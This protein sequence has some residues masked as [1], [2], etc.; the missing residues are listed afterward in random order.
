MVLTYVRML[1]LELAQ[2]LSD[3]AKNVAHDDNTDYKRLALHLFGFAHH[4]LSAVPPLAPGKAANLLASRPNSAEPP[5]PVTRVLQCIETVFSKRRHVLNVSVL[6]QEIALVV[7]ALA[8]GTPAGGGAASSD[9]LVPASP[10]LFYE[11]TV[12]FLAVWLARFA[13]NIDAATTV[14]EFLMAVVLTLAAPLNGFRYKK[15]VRDML[16]LRVASATD[17]LLGRLRA[18]RPAP[19]LA[20]DTAQLAAAVHLFAVINDHEVA[21]KLLLRLAEHQLQLEALARKL[22]FSL[23]ACEPQGSPDVLDTARSVLL[24]NMAANLAADAAVRWLL[25]ELVLTWIR[26]HWLLLRTADMAA[27]GRRYTRTGCLVLLRV[28]LLCLQRQL[29]GSFAHSF[30]AAVYTTLPEW[31]RLPLVVRTTARIVGSAYS[32]PGAAP[33]PSFGDPELDD[34]R[35]QIDNHLGNK[36][37]TLPELLVFVCG[38]EDSYETYLLQR[39]AK[40]TVKLWLEYIQ[41]SKHQLWASLDTFY[42]FLTLLRKVP[43]LLAGHWDPVSQQCTRCTTLLNKNIYADVAPLPM[44]ANSQLLLAIYIDIVRSGKTHNNP[45][46]ATNFLL[47]LFPLLASFKVPIRD[48]NHPLVDYVVRCLTNTNRDVRLLAARVLPL[49][50][51]RED[52][53]ATDALFKHFFL[54]LSSLPLSLQI[55]LGESTF[56]ALAELAI[57]SEGEWL[58]VLSIKL[59]DGLGETNEQHLNIAYNCLL[60][61]ALARAV[62]PYK[63]LSPFLPSIAER[64][65]KKPRMFAKLVELIGVSRKYFLNNT[66]EYTTPRFLEYY[67]HDF[68]QEI[69]DASSMPKLK[70]IHKMLPRIVATYLCKD[71]RIDPT[72]IINVLSNASPNYK[73]MTLDDLIP[74]V[75]EVLW[76]VLLQMHMEDNGAIRNEARIQAA[77]LYLAKLNWHKRH[78][79]EPVEA[80]SERE[81]DY[82]NDVLREHVLELVQHFS[83]NVHL[84]K[85]IKPYLE[86]VNSIKA[87]QFI[88]TRNIEAASWALGQISTCLQAAMDSPAL[89][90]H[91]LQCWNVLVQKLDSTKLV[92]LFDITISLMFQ[93]FEGFSHRCKT[94]AAEIL[95]KLFKEITTK[96]TKYGPYYY[97]YPYIKDLDKYYLLDASASNMLR[98][99]SKIAF[100]PELSR[101]LQTSNKVVVHQALDDLINSARTYQQI[102]QSESFRDASS[103]QEISQLIRDILDVAVQFKSKD[104]E[105]STKCAKV[106]GS[107]GSLDQNRFKFQTVK[108]QIIVLFDFQDPKENARFLVNFIQSKVIKNFWAS[109]DPMRQLFS[110]YAM[111]SFLS[112]LGLDPT[113]LSG[114]SQ[115]SRT[116][117]W[118]QF[119]EVDKSTLTPLLSSQYFAAKPRYEPLAFP[120]FSLGMTHEEWVV[121][122]TTNLF[123]RPFALLS[124]QIKGSR[125]QIYLTCSMLIRDQEVSISRYLLK[126]VALS[127]IVSGESSVRQDIL[128]EFL[129]VLN[130]R[131]S[132]VSGSD[133]AENLKSCYQSVFEALDYFNEWLSAATQRASD[134][135]LSKSDSNLLKNGRVLVSSFLEEISTEVIALASSECDSYERTILSLEKSY[136]DFSGDSSKQ[137]NLDIAQTLK[138]VYS[139]IDDYD[140]LDG[141][142]KKFSEANISL[143]LETFQYNENW[144]IAQESFTA[145]STNNNTSHHQ[146][147]CNTKLLK[148]FADHAL[149]DQVLSNL[150]AKL[151][152]MTSDHIPKA[153]ALAGLRAALVC[154]EFDLILKWRQISQTVG[155]PEDVDATITFQVAQSILPF[156][157]IKSTQV[158]QTSV[159]ASSLGPTDQFEKNNNKLYAVIG[160]ALSLSLSSSFSR[161]T[162]LMRQ[163]HMMF[164]LA[165]ILSTL[166]FDSTTTDDDLLYILEE[167]LKNADC[168]FDSQWQIL[169][170]HNLC[171]KITRRNK[172]VSKV[173]IKA[174]RLARAEK[175]LD[176]AT[177]CIMKAMVLQDQ[178]ATV[179]YA[180]LIWDQGKKAEAIKIMAENLKFGTTK[181]QA[182]KQ[183]QYALWL[184][185][186]SHTSSA[187][188]IEEYN[189]A[190]KLDREWEKPFFDLGKY[191]SKIMESNNDRSGHHERHIIRLYL[192]ALKLGTTYIFEALPK[193]ITVWLDFAQDTKLSRDAKRRLEQIVEDINAQKDEVPMYVW[194]TSITQL[195]SRITHTHKPSAEVI[196]HVIYKLI[197]TYPKHSLWYVLSHVKSKDKTRSDR[198]S[199]VLARVQQDP[200]LA[201]HMVQATELFDILKRLA[202]HT[203]KKNNNKRWLLSEDFNIHDTKRPYD[204]LVIPVKSNLEIRIPATLRKNNNWHAFPRAASIT[205]DGFDEEVSIFSSLQM[206][207][208]ITIRGSDNKPYRLMVKRDDTRKDAKVFE[209]TNMMNKLLSR[210]V[211]A[212]KR[213]LV[214]E[215]YS[216]IPLAEDMGVIEFV[217]NVATMKAVTQAQ[218][219]KLGINLHERKIAARLKEAQDTLKAQ[220]GTQEAQ[221]NLIRQFQEIC[222]EIPPVL[223]SWFVEQFSDPAVWYMARKSFTRTAAVMSIVGYIIGLGDRH[224]ENVLFLKEN[225]SVL[226]IDFDC[227]FDKGATLPTPEI[228]PFRL[229]QNMVDVMGTTGIEGTFRITCEVAAALVRQNEAPLMNILETLIHDPLLDWKTNDKSQKHLP[230]V[231]RKIRGL[232]NEFDGLPVSVHGQVDVL[233]Q[234]ATSVQ[235][236]SRMY[237]GWTPHI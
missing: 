204:L 202:A 158:P 103:E 67:K 147:D 141:V 199:R 16:V 203:V 86:K 226:H 223:H 88:I 181:Q 234:Q 219:K 175:R 206:P 190:Y 94:I 50:L 173:L 184:D 84:M 83:E 3:V 26:D 205:F 90:L 218:H 66:R 220:A 187:D 149:H 178:E 136:R 58:C 91:A 99:K 214:I 228:V 95:L 113:V 157:E 73:R 65:I 161:N 230:T 85:G 197:G 98:L 163:L 167:R 56:L 159:R 121:D 195:L 164:D 21:Q 151:G 128:D 64:I 119:S 79:E 32:E 74:N 108:Q 1:D 153:W 132:T 14:K 177:K 37:A 77:I 222:A 46:L 174:S 236:L 35:R 45:L 225:G 120:H 123:R 78:H 215:N 211:D 81:F 80:P 12:H 208:Q 135:L 112:I 25:L 63:L 111:Q 5:V 131:M 140:A 179:E 212:R 122:I 57:I 137:I 116:A 42:T 169:T 102:W 130:T 69:A 150:E 92:S 61:I 176:I 127:H 210:S 146:K 142:L 29:A 125:A 24:L 168:Q 237:I 188:I 110:V 109:N 52:G 20:A 19:F 48:S 27:V 15:T 8:P 71:D 183:L 207:K 133:K 216:V 30:D 97:S 11:W 68:I 152:L 198:V 49:F 209:F 138:S 192:H 143:K 10:V 193:L 189:K 155:I 18:A 213:K 160:Q 33:V 134:T 22:A 40:A 224:C 217:L 171:N 170:S 101:R 118:N 124:S 232:M 93:K 105:I 53:Q 31:G 76:F 166:K 145:L 231:R 9:E 186:S 221:N 172:E 23:A 34:V 191:H 144:T 70:L 39:N 117:V 82:I 229:T 114:D 36:T 235:N 13:A 44:D 87:V 54:T 4:K 185:E 47:A 156:L 51:I 89:E 139:G 233:I 104:P 154:G 200:T 162:G 60:Y 55:H 180:H 96:Y 17:R 38:A 194:Y 107:L 28:Y 7:S 115:A 148:S 100:F 59:V 182:R 126:Y 165:L 227:L 43:C 72:Y 129:A 62:T 41:A 6:P 201:T 75:G 106:L 196:M 2:L